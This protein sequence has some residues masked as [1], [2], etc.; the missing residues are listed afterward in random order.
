MSKLNGQTVMI[1]GAGGGLGTSLVAGVLKQN[2]RVIAVDKDVS[3]LKLQYRD[4]QEELQNRLTIV[5]TE[6]G[7]PESCKAAIQAATSAS[8]SIAVLICTTGDLKV[9]RDIVTAADCRKRF[10]SNFFVPLQLLESF[11]KL[12]SS[13]ERHE[14]L[15]IVVVSSQM[16][17]LN[18]AELFDYALPKWSLEIA[19]R[20]L[21]QKLNATNTRILIVKRDDPPC[22]NLIHAED[23]P[24]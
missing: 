12:R 10:D 17:G 11:L 7:G 22:D 5:E 1:A 3:S 15:D 21:Q 18:P 8:K 2:G 14:A 4:S 23:R 19:V 9:H 6:L 16:V 13:A 24:F 20:Q